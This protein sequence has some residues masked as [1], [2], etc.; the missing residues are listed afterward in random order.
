MAR[1]SDQIMHAFNCTSEALNTEGE[2]VIKE[3]ALLFY[4][5][6]HF[7]KSF[8]VTENMHLNMHSHIPGHPLSFH[9]RNND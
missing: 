1:I 4:K 6:L 5:T 2:I 8:I 3:H 7:P 9:S